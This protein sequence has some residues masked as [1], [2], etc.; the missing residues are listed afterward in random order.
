VNQWIPWIADYNGQ[1]P[2]T[3]TPWT[4]CTGENIW[5]GTSAWTVWQYT[6]TGTIPG[7]SGNVDHDVFN[8]TDSTLISTL[9]IG[10]GDSARLGSTSVP[11]GVLPGQTFTATITLTNNGTSAWTNNGANPYKLGSQNP[12]DNTTW[13]T[14]RV[15]LASSPINPAQNAT[16][17]FNA[18]APITPGAYIFAWKMVQEGVQWFGQTFSTTINV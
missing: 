3:S 13:G 16:F 17:T 4:V 7:I 14:N 10:G 18:T 15:L 6:S 11:T 9:V 12:Q 8:G 2:Q 1:D 5:G